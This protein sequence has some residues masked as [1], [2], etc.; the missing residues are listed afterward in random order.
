MQLFRPSNREY[1]SLPLDNPIESPLN[2]R[3]IFDNTAL[4][5]LPESIRTQGVC[6]LYWC[7]PSTRKPTRW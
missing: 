4:N 5:E 1:R 3:R 2:P 7:D 6:S